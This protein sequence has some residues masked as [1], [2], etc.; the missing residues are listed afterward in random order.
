[1]KDNRLT[2]ASKPDRCPRCGAPVYKILYGEPCMSEEDYLTTYGEH[3]IF[4][5]C[6]LT[7]DD[8]AWACS[9]CGAE[10]FKL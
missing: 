2:S 7:G 1:M 10:I 9:Q 8:P 4:G 3:V 6:I 5:G